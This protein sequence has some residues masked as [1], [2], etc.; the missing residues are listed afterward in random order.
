MSE[1]KEPQAEDKASPA[2][3]PKGS[4][5]KPYHPPKLEVAGDFGDVTLGSSPYGGYP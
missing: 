3:K 5:K 2:V 1:K 4:T